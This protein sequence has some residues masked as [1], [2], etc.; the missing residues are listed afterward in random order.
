[1]RI[2]GYTY[3]EIG[4][5][6]DVS[7]QYIH[8]WMHALLCGSEEPLKKVIYPAIKEWLR[9]NQTSIHQLSKQSGLSATYLYRILYGKCLPGGKAIKS[10]LSITGLTYEEAFRV[11]D[12]N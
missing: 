5:K 1:M 12:N 2:D 6:L 7:R 9:L 10:I 8:Q 3:E 11:D 4:A